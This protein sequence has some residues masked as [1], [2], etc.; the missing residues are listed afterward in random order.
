[1]SQPV[2]VKV[3][4]LDAIRSH[5]YANGFST[6]QALAD[7][8]GASLATVR[9][10]LQILE[11]EGAID[12]VHGGARIAEG[13]SVEVAFQE[14]EKRHL[15]AK[16]AIATAAYD[17]LH[18]RTAIF[19]DAGTTVLQLAR[20]VRINPMPLRIFTNGLTV[21][22]E[23]LNIPN[24]EVVLLGGQLRSENASLVGPQAEAMLET[25]WF[26][27]L[28]LGASAIS[29]DGAIY[30]VD[31][32]EASLNRRMLARSA[33]RFVLADSSKFGTTATYKVAPLDTAKVIT[34]SGLSRHW[35]EELVN[36]GVDATIADLRAKE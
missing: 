11:Q 14:R 24:L 36:F 23:F 32:A 22:Q 9:R 31:S 27:Q 8:I 25:L 29:S 17:L 19:L 28:F 16:R 3:D 20:L 21:A 26:D 18:P 12:R 4:R 1:M 15:S 35:R 7:A 34:D 30:S 33:N 2:G 5:L 6:I 13:S 10:D